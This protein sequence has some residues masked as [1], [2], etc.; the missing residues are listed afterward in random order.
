V[1]VVAD[2]LAASSCRTA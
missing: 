2:R 1:P